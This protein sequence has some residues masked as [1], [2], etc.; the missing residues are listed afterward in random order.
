MNFEVACIK[1][2]ERACELVFSITNICRDSDTALPP[3]MIRSITQFSEYVAPVYRWGQLSLKSL[4]RTLQKILTFMRS[5]VKGGLVKRIHQSTEN[6]A[7]INECN[8]G[9]NH[10]L[11]VCGVRRSCHVSTLYC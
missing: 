9:L 5:Q 7:L 11:G 4:S 10:A 1:M 6:M 3:A 2:S 8:A